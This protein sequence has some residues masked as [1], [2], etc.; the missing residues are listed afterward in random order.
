M[1]VDQDVYDAVIVAVNRGNETAT[2]SVQVPAAW[3]EQ[4]A[5]ELITGTIAES[6]RDQ[7]TVEVPPLETRIYTP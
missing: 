5:Q 2:A 4:V 1:T 7:L 3:G 6:D